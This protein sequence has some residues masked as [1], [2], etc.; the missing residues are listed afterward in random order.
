M[1]SG[2]GESLNTVGK[3][4]ACYFIKKTNRTKNSKKNKSVEDTT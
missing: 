3:I 4:R 1:A 2:T